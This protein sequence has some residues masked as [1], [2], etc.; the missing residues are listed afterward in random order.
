MQDSI[1]HWETDL[2]KSNRL[3]SGF[4]SVSSLYV[5]VLYCIELYNSSNK[6]MFKRCPIFIE[7]FCTYT[8]QKLS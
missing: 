2:D 1:S 4:Q 8:S 3:L 7:D 5:L 6:Y